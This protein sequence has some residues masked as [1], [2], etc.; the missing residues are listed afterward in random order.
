MPIDKERI[1]RAAGIQW[2]A[3][4]IS[5]IVIARESGRSSNP[6]A[7]SASGAVH[8]RMTCV[9]WIARFRGQ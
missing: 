1:S 9:Y 8:H 4:P 3:D 6:C 7:S 5:A 2:K